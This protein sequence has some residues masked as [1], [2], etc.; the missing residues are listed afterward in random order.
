MLK[1]QWRYPCLLK[2]DISRFPLDIF[3]LGQFSAGHFLP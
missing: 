2:M 1:L 3:S